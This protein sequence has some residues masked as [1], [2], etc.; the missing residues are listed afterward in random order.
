[1]AEAQTSVGHGLVQNTHAKAVTISFLASGILVWI[2]GTVLLQTLILTLPGRYS[3]MLS[4]DLMHHGVPFAMGLITFAVLQMTPKVRVWA[5]DVVAEI[6]RIVWPSRQETVA[7]TIGVCVLIMA[8][9]LIL[10][11]MDVISGS[12]VDWLLHQQFGGIFG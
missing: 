5:E 10:G 12:L 9:G 7:R 6:Y 1:M 8:A 3:A 2:T 4:T 11:L